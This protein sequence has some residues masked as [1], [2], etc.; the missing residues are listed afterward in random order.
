MD[1]KVQKDL[2][3]FRVHIYRSRRL[4]DY[5]N[6]LSKDNAHVLVDD[7]VK[8]VLE[9]QGYYAEEAPRSI[10]SVEKLFQALSQYAPGKIPKLLVDAEVRRGIALAYCCF[11]NRDPV[12]LKHIMP[13]TPDTISTITSNPRGSSGLTNYGVSKAESAT[14]AL[15]RGLQTLK[16]EKAPEPC[17]G[18]T[19]TQFKEKTRLVWGYP[20]SM[21]AIEGLV[22]YPILQEFKKGNT[23]MA[24]AMPTG[25]LGTKLRVSSYHKC[26]AYSL[27]FSQF[28]ASISRDLIHIAFNII[29]TWFD[30]DEVEPVSGKTVRDVFHLIERYFVHTTIVMPDGNIYLGKDHG[31][32]SGSYF[33]QMVDSICNVIIGGTISAKF[34]L[35]V[36]KREIFVLGDDLLMWSNRHMD[37]DVIAKYANKIFGVHLHGSEKSA[38]Y[39]YDEPIHY[40]GRDWV[41]GLPTLDVGEVL[42]R[43]VYPESFRRYSEDP[44]ARDRQVRML[45]LSYAAVYRSAWR[46]AASCIDP[47]AGNAKQGCSNFDVNTYIR[48]KGEA[49]LVPQMFS[50]LQRYLLRFRTGSDTHDIPITAMQYWI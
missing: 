12:K 47:N 11:G 44:A 18:L 26:W 16:G 13:F 2:E 3:L 36:S 38:I 9:A 7:H 30:M 4:K 40:L 27:D 25:V 21:T 48:D 50:G 31:V 28:D 43:M 15:E 37:L 24:F 39:K 45:L 29:R 49:E 6:R 46:V 1:Q 32:P 17:L 42:K 33:T 23:P 20:Y 22:A 41:N 8:A 19:R 34:S 10:Y 5:Y 35:N 14:R